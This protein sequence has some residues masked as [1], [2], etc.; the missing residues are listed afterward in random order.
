M[1]MI[2][3]DNVTFAYG[4][5]EPV[6]R[7]WSWQSNQGDIWCVLGP[8]GCGKSTLLLLLAGLILPQQGIITIGG[9]EIARPRPG[10]GLVLQEYGLLPWAN[11]WHNVALG[12][13]IRKF[14]GPDG[15][16]VPRDV[17]YKEDE[18]KATVDYWLNRLGITEIAK[19]YPGQVSGG[20]RQRAAIARAFVLNPD[21]LLMDEPFSALDA[22]TREN[23]EIL[24]LALSNEVGLSVVLVTHSI[25]EAAFVGQRILVLSYPP[26]DDAITVDNPHAPDSEYRASNAYKSVVQ[27]LR[28]KVEQG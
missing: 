10:T 28:N 26:N 1:Q 8:S 25:E 24:T 13:K 19:Q 3:L 21:I 12:L 6:F 22:P 18:A 4:N 14:Y 11:I 2:H 27:E 9:K 16:H 23:L 5:Q 15:R 17:R 7:N 20:Q